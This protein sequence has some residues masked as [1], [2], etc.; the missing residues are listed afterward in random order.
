VRVESAQCLCQF[1]RIESAQCLCRFGRIESAQCLCQ[2]GR[3][4]YFGFFLRAP[5]KKCLKQAPNGDV[6]PRQ[7]AYLS[8]SGNH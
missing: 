7:F 4:E 3:I 8:L 6:S 1:D 5:R 2:F